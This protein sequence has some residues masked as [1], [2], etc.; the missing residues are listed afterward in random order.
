MSAN[1][2]ILGVIL[3]GGGSS[4]MFADS[5]ENGDKALLDLAGRPM[6]AHVVERVQ[7]QVPRLVLNANGNPDR[8]KA[9][10]LDVVADVPRPGARP[11]DSHRHGRQGP[12]A[13]LHAALSFAH[14]LDAAVTTIATVSSDVPFLPL[15]VVRRLEA[16]REAQKDRIAYAACEGQRHPTIALW[17]LALLEAVTRALDDGHLSLDRFARSNGA[18]EVAFPM[19]NIGGHRFDPFFNANTPDDLAWARQVMA[20]SCT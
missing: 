17:P 13:G 7:P 10:G 6:L 4:R 9:F 11:D 18:I 12:L 5:G 1:T 16:G 19:G 2:A 20:A 3:A 14:R 15:D 8:F